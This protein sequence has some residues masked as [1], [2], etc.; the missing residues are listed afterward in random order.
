MC[1]V[2]AGLLVSGLGAQVALWDPQG[3]FLDG[4]G[5]LRTK[6]TEDGT[7]LSDLRKEAVGKQKSDEFVYISLPKLLAEAKSLID[8]GDPLPDRIRYLGGMV[9]LQYVFVYPDDKDLVIAGPAEPIDAKNTYRPLGKT[10]GRPVLQLDD[11]VTAF[12]MSGPGRQPAR[13]GCD[14]EMTADGVKRASE[15]IKQVAR[16]A[17]SGKISEEEASDEVAKAGGNQPV[18]YYGA[19]ADTRFGFVCVEADYLLKH[20]GIGHFTSPV[21][22]VK[23]YHERCMKPEKMHRFSL[24]SQYDAIVASKDNDAFEFKGPSLE[25]RTGLLQRLGPQDGEPSRAAKMFVGACNKNFEE[26]ALHIESWS[27]LANLGD[28]TVLAALVAR[29]GLHSKTGW[30][31][32]WVLDGYPVPR[33]ETPKFA[34]TLANYRYAS[35]MLFFTSGGIWLNPVKWVNEIQVDETETLARPA[36]LEGMMVTESAPGV[37]TVPAS[38]KWIQSKVSMARNF[39]NN[40]KNEQAAA[41]LE[42]ILAKY[43]EATDNEA[44]QALRDDLR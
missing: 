43:P 37:E 18:T 20:L 11:L 5:V 21:P 40:E 30:D 17:A 32:G 28:L 10:S 31:L 34:W 4:H 19:A 3:V 33:V 44:V 39:L 36:H 23:S 24:E 2:L 16:K 14:I 25:V 26:M 9:K 8:N 42:E 35:N 41:I 29:E 38:E 13:I 15:T 6:V 12:R 22:G 27:D 7:R 1:V